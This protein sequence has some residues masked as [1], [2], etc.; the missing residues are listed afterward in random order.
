MQKWVILQARYFVNPGLPDKIR[1]SQCVLENQMM[2][3]VRYQ[4]IEVAVKHRPSRRGY[5][6]HLKNIQ[7]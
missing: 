5:K 4:F 2:S 1:F 6:P 3:Y 7:E